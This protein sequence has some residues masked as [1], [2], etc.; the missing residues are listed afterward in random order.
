MNNLYEAMKTFLA[1]QTVAAMKIHNVHWFMVGEGFFPMHGLMDEY[2]DQAQER[3]DEVAE[4]LLM[5]GDKP[6]GSLA[7]I[8]ERTN[9]KELG[10]DKVSAVEGMKHLLVDFELLASASRELIK[11]S[12][13]ADD[14]GTADLFT[15]I[16]RDLDKTVWMLKAYTHQAA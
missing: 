5:I 11:L 9:I 13:E 14:A 2:Y 16:L 8:L 15:A 6:L 10:T 4:R 12:E 7:K 3:I 1:D